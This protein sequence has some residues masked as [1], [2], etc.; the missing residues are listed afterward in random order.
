LL[1]C[2]I[3]GHC[4]QPRPDVWAPHLRQHPHHL[5]GAQLKHLQE[6]FSS[7]RLAAPEDVDV[8]SSGKTGPARAI[9]GLRVVDGWQCLV[10]EEGL[11]R[12]LATMKVH[13]SKVHQQKPGGHKKQPL[14]R[15]C[16]LQTYFAENRLIRYFVV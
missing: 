6:L 14:W 1:L 7:Y 13:V 12:S 16:K 4:L 8:P 15:A 2:T 11:T 10:C 3:C 5:R 9:R